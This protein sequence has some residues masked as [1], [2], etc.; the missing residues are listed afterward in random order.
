MKTHELARD[1]R[2]LA[3]F[4]QKLPNGEL[5]EALEETRIDNSPPPSQK[6]DQDAMAVNVATLAALAR[7]GKSRWVDF[8][9]EWKLPI[10]SSRKDSARNIMGEV[11][12]YLDS[13]PDDI[14]RLQQRMTKGSKASPALMKALSILMQAPNDNEES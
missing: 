6:A 7:V 9:E 8:I 1:L 13:H 2:E 4:L 11:M 3:R 10:K 5:K 14:R 12:R